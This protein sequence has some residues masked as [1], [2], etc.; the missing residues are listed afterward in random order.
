MTHAEPRAIERTLVELLL[1]TLRPAMEELVA[2]FRRELAQALSA[3][4]GHA[5]D[6]RPRGQLGRP[7]CCGVCKLKGARNHA[8]LPAGHTQE[9]HRRWKSGAGSAVARL[10]RRGGRSLAPPRSA[11][12]AGS[13]RAADPAARVAAT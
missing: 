3:I 4:G 12:R 13:A 2:K 8:A 6:E 5:A 7:K 1:K 10:P 11:A 9:D